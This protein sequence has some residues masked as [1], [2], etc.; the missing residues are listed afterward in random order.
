MNSSVSSRLFRQNF[1]L[2]KSDPASSQTKR[3]SKLPFRLRILCTAAVFAAGLHAHAATVISTI[4]QWGGSGGVSP[5]GDNGVETYGQTFIA[6]SESELTQITFFLN[7]YGTPTTPYSIDFKVYV[8]AWN[9][10]RASGPI[11]FQSVPL[12]TNSEGGIDGYERLDISTGGID[13]TPGTKYVAFMSVSDFPDRNQGGGV[14]G[15]VQDSSIDAYPGGEFVYIGNGTDTSLW[16]TS[17]WDRQ[18]APQDLAFAFQF[19]PVPE[20]ASAGL[21]AMA[22]AFALTRRRSRKD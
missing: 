17:S 4:P 14:A 20:P 21:C 22:C 13:L 2:A 7:D 5:F 9:T 18:F 19:Q 10:D 3:S 1:P 16:T 8:M 11:L 6:P 12:Q 15:F